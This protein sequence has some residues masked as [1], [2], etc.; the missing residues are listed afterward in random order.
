MYVKSQP[1]VQSPVS[2]NLLFDPERLVTCQLLE[3]EAIDEF[4]GISEFCDY[5]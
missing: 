3:V 1:Q 4:C 2:N 5:S